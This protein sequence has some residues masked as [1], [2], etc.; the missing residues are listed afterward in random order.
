M[1]ASLRHFGLALLGP[2]LFFSCSQAAG[3][4]PTQVIV[5]T[6]DTTRADY[7]GLGG[8]GKTLVPHLAALARDSV[9]FSECYSTTNS[10]IP[11]HTSLFT[12]SY[13]KDHKITSMG[14]ELPEYDSFLAK[15]F[16]AAGFRTAAFT[17]G[18]H[19]T[20]K[21]NFDQGFD[22]FACPE[23]VCRADETR[24]KAVHWIEENRGRDFFLWVHFFDSHMPYEPPSPFDRMYDDVSAE[25][26]EELPIHNEDYVHN[27]KY[28]D[29]SNDPQYYRNLYRGEISYL[30]AQI[31]LLLDTLR[32]TGIYDDC[33]I[34]LLADHGEYLGEHTI[35][36]HHGGGIYDEV[37]HVPL[38]VKAG[39]AEYTG[40]RDQLV[41][42]VDVYPTLLDLLGLQPPTAIRGRSLVPLLQSASA[43]EVREAVYY[44]SVWQLKMG[45][46]TRQQ[47]YIRELN[48]VEKFDEVDGFKVV[49]TLERLVATEGN[50]QLFDNA[51]DP[52]QATNLATTRHELA[53]AFNQEA[54][55]FADDVLSSS[56]EP[57]QVKDPAHYELLKQLGYTE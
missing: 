33:T 26:L 8:E 2:L 20:P 16:Q 46:K 25:S 36:F 22:E 21:I 55:Q 42:S 51:A 35:Y 37:I 31:G 44:E 56:T 49:N 24:T 18:G 3:K 47:T 19:L 5:I 43:A 27:W 34:V 54:L 30:D 7:L 45:I 23:T 9:V 28:F 13:L 52:H 48:R 57:M 6:L 38:L 1:R 12:S 15:V 50:E 41:S 53:A 17:S 4:T 11:A 14:Q 29:Q 39:Q 10:T 32:T 40:K